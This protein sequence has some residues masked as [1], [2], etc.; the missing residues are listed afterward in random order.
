MRR[1]LALLLLLFALPLVSAASVRLADALGKSAARSLDAA[2]RG[3][4]APRHEPPAPVFVEAEVTPPTAE[5]PP[6]RQV[7]VRRAV[8]RAAQIPKKGIRVRADVVLRLAN[9]GLRPSGIP[10]AARGDRPAG[11]A[12]SGVSA[13]G[14]GLVDGDVLTSAAGRPAL[15][16]GD[17]IGVVIGSR[18]KGV[19]E[20]C[21]RFWRD[22]EPWNLIVEQPY[23]A[24]RHPHAVARR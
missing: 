21:G 13:L 7:A 22:G 3:L 12:L 5:P 4:F 14:I 11:L 19:R 9:A 20:I 17:V 18:A 1:A 23:V 10:V 2:T 24:P 15:S 16:A 6:A 8:V